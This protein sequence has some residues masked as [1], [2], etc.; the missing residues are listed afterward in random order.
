MAENDTYARVLSL[1]AELSGE[2]GLQP[3]TRLKEDLG[4]D[5][6]ELVQLVMDLNRSFGITIHS[7]EIS[8]VHFAT[9]RALA[10]F[11]DSKQ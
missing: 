3:E 7:A 10:D 4:L 5:S 2:T 9:A 11:I 8:P 1:L 6:I